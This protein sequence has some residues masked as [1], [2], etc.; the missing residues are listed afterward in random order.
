MTAA[1]DQLLYA[2][3]TVTTQIKQLEAEWG[4]KLF[5]KEGRGV[6]L[7]SEGRA[8]LAKAKA[9][10]NQV[11]V[12]DTI[13]SSIQQGGAGHIRIGAIEPVGTWQVAPILA[14]FM[15]N[16]PLLQL[17]FETG[18][19]YSISERVLNRNLEIALVQYAGKKHKAY[20]ERLFTEQLVLVMRDDHPLAQQE[21]VVIDDLRSVRLILTEAAWSY[22]GINE[23]DLVY[24]GRDYPYANI[25]VNSVGMAI[26]FVQQ[27]IGVALLPEICLNQAP[28]NFIFCTVEDGTF[29]REIGLISAVPEYKQQLVVQELIAEL[30]HHLKQ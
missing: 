3:S 2:Q 1:A 4:V 5:R 9:V 29:E 11:D 8:I 30:R 7:T 12:L 20:Y 28:D 24:Y 10:I 19:Y 13:V 16:R 26:A 17:N 23:N 27:C 22:R 25:E 14:R 6:K 15:E 21:K 18:S